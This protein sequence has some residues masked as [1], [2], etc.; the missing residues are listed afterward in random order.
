M[1]P[2]HGAPWTVTGAR[3]RPGLGSA[4]AHPSPACL[5]TR[6]PASHQHRCKEEA[7]AMFIYMAAQSVV[8]DA[9]EVL[10]MRQCR[11]QPGSQC[12]VANSVAAALA[13]HTSKPY[14]SLCLLSSMSHLNTG[15]SGKVNPVSSLLDPP[16]RAP[17]R[18]PP[19]VHR[20]ACWEALTVMAICQ[21]PGFWMWGRLAGAGCLVPTC[22]LQQPGTLPTCCNVMRYSLDCILVTFS[23]GLKHAAMHTTA[24][25]LPSASSTSNPSC[26]DLSD[27]CTVLP[28]LHLTLSSISYQHTSFPAGLHQTTCAACSIIDVARCSRLFAR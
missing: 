18:G 19:C 24:F 3:G 12:H 28:L 4:G 7:A 25:P 15:Q 26:L 13:Q 8:T 22:L 2:F 23:F 20:C 21:M 11:L 10:N 17:L 1:H 5:T 9:Y 6:C 16:M 27:T 14:A